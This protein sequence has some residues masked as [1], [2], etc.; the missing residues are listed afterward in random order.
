MTS[1][2]DQLEKSRQICKKQYFYWFLFSKN[3]IYKQEIQI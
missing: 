2:S 3:L 1:K